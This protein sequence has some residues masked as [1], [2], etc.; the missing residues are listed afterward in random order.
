VVR[1]QNVTEHEYNDR[2][3]AYISDRHATFLV[4]NKVV[5]CDVLI[6]G[7][8]EDRYPVGRACIYPAQLPPSVNKADCFRARCIPEV[9]Q[10]KFFMLFLNCE[11]ARR[12]IRRF[13]QG[14]TRPR[15]NTG[16][17][18][19]LYVGVPNMG[20]QTFFIEKFDATQSC[21]HIQQANVEKLQ[22]QKLGLMQDLLT[23]KVPV[24]CEAEN[25]SMEP[26]A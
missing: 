7:L 2:D 19:R 3:K 1:L 22:H 18:K 21:I 15:I 16:N 11:L 4:R 6:A 26:A 14:V 9:M 25:T 12:Q 13:E 10:N 5:G 24:K 17:L 23:G 8:G 20:E